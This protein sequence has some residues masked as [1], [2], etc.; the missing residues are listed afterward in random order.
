MI[1]SR[2]Q[3]QHKQPNFKMWSQNNELWTTLRVYA[4]YDLMPKIRI[5]LLADQQIQSTTHIT[6][7]HKI[8]KISKMSEQSESMKCLLHCIS[9]WYSIFGLIRNLLCQSHFKLIIQNIHI[10]KP[11]TQQIFSGILFSILDRIDERVLIFFLNFGFV[12]HSLMCET[13]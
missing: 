4:V 2:S 9:D 10:I 12:Q 6:H 8:S 5:N 13:F 11:F 3:G 1:V 7:K